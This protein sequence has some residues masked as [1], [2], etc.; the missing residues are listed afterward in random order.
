MRESVA[1]TETSTGGEVVAGDRK[2]LY[3]DGKRKGDSGRTDEGEE[4]VYNGSESRE[5]ENDDMK[6]NSLTGVR[7]KG[8]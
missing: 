5:E 4:E 6:S 3:P 1:I 8:R 2:R 7:M